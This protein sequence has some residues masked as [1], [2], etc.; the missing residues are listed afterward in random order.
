MPQYVDIEMETYIIYEK[1]LQNGI[2]SIWV[3]LDFIQKCL[4]LCLKN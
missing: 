3:K 2:L 4:L 1:I